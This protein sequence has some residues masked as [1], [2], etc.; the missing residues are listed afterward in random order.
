MASKLRTIA[1][2]LWI[3]EA[4]AKM[5]FLTSS[6]LAA[7]F[8]DG[9]RWSANKRLRKLLDAGLLNVWVRSLSEENIY[10]ITKRGLNTVEDNNITPMHSIKTPRGL[11]ENLNHLLAIND[12]RASLA[13]S[14]PEANAE[15]I[16]WR[17]DW[18]LRAHGRERIIPDGLFLIKWNEQKEQVYA[19]E[20]DNNTKSA[21]NFLKKIL[22]YA[23]FQARGLS[24][25][26]VSE[27]IVLV[28]CA[29]PKW[30]ER[31]HMSI[32]QLRLNHWIWFAAVKDIKYAGAACAIWVTG[33]ARKY[34][35]R[36]LTFRP[37]GK[38]GVDDETLSK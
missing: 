17:S 38:E 20:V 13:S 5:R 27:P 32:K 37:Y 2:D 29:H 24:I 23:S 21:K 10:S 28:A 14:L 19:L 3:L 11:D 9:S 36:E 1:R 12:V 26:G 25:Y 33:G 15:I 35:L 6:Q 18:E 16:W 4:L 8:F 31:Y 34:S 22:A 30:M 7:L